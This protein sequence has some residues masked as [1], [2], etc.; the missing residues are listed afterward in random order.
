MRGKAVERSLA[1]QKLF[2]SDLDE[3][4]RKASLSTRI[5]GLYYHLIETCPSSFRFSNFFRRLMPQV[6]LSMR[7]RK[8]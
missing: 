7:Q 3:R 2:I 5:L 8:E 6:S 4:A 1:A